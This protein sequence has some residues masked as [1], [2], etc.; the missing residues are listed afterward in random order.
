MNTQSVHLVSPFLRAK[1]MARIR[2]MA[3]IMNNPKMA[4]AIFHLP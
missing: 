2:M 4:E 1:I 3:G